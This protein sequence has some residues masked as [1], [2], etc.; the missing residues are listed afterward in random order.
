MLEGAQ[1]AAQ[2]CQI[3][4]EGVLAHDGA[5]RPAGADEIAAADGFAWARHQP[6]EQPELG[7]CQCH[8]AGG[9]RRR[10]VDGVQAQTGDLECAV[11]AGA[12]E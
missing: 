8:L 4:V 7:R 1:L 6:C 10:V 9:V 2:P 5:V 11:A 3:G 12:A